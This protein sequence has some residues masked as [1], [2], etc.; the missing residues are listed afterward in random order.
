MVGGGRLKSVAEGTTTVPVG[1]WVDGT[2]EKRV[3]TPM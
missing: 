2:D 1:T 3:K